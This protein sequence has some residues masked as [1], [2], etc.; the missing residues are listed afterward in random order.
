MHS[1]SECEGE[2]AAR[3]EHGRRDASMTPEGAH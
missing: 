3:G 2:D 1:T